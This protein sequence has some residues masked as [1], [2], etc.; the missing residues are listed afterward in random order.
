MSEDKD[1]YLEH[2]WVNIPKREVKII[3]DEGY[4][5]KVVWKFDD[6]GA[7]GFTETLATFKHFIPD[8]MITYLPRQ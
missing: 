2:I 3:D 7:E 8:D 5:E 6:E 4:D 1:T